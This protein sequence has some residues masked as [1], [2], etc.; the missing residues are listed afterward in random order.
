[1]N[2]RRTTPEEIDI[3]TEVKTRL[4]ESE[5]QTTRGA[6]LLVLKPQVSRMIGRF[7][8]A[9]L[10]ELIE[11]GTG[12]SAAGVLWSS[13]IATFLFWTEGGCG[14]LG[15]GI[16]IHRS[17]PSWRKSSED[18]DIDLLHLTITNI[19]PHSKNPPLSS[20][21][22]IV[23]A[24]CVLCCFTGCA[25]FTSTSTTRVRVLIMIFYFFGFWDRGGK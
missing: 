14:M 10:R 5:Q 8:D 22:S 16:Y 7:D 15:D 9:V 23:F 21:H 13:W 19:F 18:Q 20:S 2:K 4:L 6:R 24:R 11:R 12:A 1:M 25:R 3:A 17:S